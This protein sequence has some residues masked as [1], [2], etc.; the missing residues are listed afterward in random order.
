[1]H[2]C[3]HNTHR[4]ACISK[5]RHEFAIRTYT[6]THNSI[7]F[8]WILLL[9]HTLHK[10][11][12]LATRLARRKLCPPQKDH[13]FHGRF[14]YFHTACVQYHWGQEKLPARRNMYPKRKCIIFMADLTISITALQHYDE[15]CGRPHFEFCERKCKSKQNMACAQ[16]A[17]DKN[18]HVCVCCLTPGR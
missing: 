7:V 10:D 5:L 8:I 15:G 18:S 16:V 3:T 2:T 11:Q 14:D 12:R 9:L 13:G 6:C 4:R 1:M 17:V